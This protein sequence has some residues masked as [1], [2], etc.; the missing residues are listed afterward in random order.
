MVPVPPY[1]TASGEPSERFCAKRFVVVALVVVEFARSRPVKESAGAV[2]VPVTTRLVVVAS[3]AA[4]E[5]NEPSVA[6]NDDALMDAP[7]IEPPVIVAFLIA[8]PTS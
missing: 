1:A 3:V 2:S 6:L 7:E 5:P 4:R 8:V